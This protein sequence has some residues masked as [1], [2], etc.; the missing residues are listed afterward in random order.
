[1]SRIVLFDAVGTILRPQPDVISAYHRAGA[2]HGSQLSIEEVA[3]RFR[4]ARQA[5]FHLNRSAEQT[6]A[7]SL[8]SSD[9]IEYALWRD[10]IQDVFADVDRVDSLFGDLWNHFASAEN[11]S[12]YDDVAACWN[13]LAEAGF[14]IAV[15]SNFDSRL[16]VI[17]KNFPQLSLAEKNCCSAEVG[18][19]KPDPAF[20][21][22]VA[23]MLR[24]SDT[25]EVYFVGDD[26]E[27]DFVA[28][29][30]FGWTAFHL[31]RRGKSNRRGAI[32]SL[33]RLRLS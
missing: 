19:R 25:D 23:S 9:E 31:D 29:Q 10:L 24:L 20:Y 22:A 33:D 14:R 13:R 27:N 28:P 17:V 11:W 32:L 4:V 7:G 1:M 15:A 8:R 18:F 5:R 2:A 3:A 30:R 16:H 26:R 12:L 21:S 6:E